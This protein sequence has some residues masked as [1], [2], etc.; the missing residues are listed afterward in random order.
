MHLYAIRSC[1]IVCKNIDEQI[2]AYKQLGFALLRRQPLAPERAL[3]LGLSASYPS[4]LLKTEDAHAPCLEI[5]EANLPSEAWSW[6]ALRVLVPDLDALANKLPEGFRVLA[7]HPATES[8][9]RSISV[10]G[11]AGE[12]LYLYQRKGDQEQPIFAASV[13]SKLPKLSA[14]F[15]LGLGASSQTNLFPDPATCGVHLGSKHCLQFADERLSNQPRPT[16]TGIYLV[17]LA[18]RG[19]RL[20]S[21]PLRILRGPDLELIELA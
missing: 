9:D 4:A 14:A 11:P 12:I 21:G 20:Q 19:T 15:Y 5:I 3:E 17:T 1:T 8:G 16:G 2:V 18:R 13:A 7:Q 10:Q 6:Y